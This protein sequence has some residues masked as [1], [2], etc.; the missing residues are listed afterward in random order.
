MIALAGRRAGTSVAFGL[1]CR[2]KQ[3][4]EANRVGPKQR[5]D[6]D[7]FGPNRTPSRASARR[8]CRSSDFT[9]VPTSVVGTQPSGPA[10]VNDA[11]R[12][13]GSGSAAPRTR[14]QPALDFAADKT[15]QPLANALARSPWRKSPARPPFA[16]RASSRRPSACR[17]GRLA[18]GPPRPDR[19]RMRRRLRWRADAPAPRPRC[20][21][22]GLRR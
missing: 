21:A 13:T 14:R 2:P 5:L 12:R 15:L 8:L 22:R 18:K 20:A 1:P 4:S 7:R 17:P 11:A 3:R 9:A 6:I 19:A 16:A 10:A